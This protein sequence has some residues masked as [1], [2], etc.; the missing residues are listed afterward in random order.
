MDNGKDTDKEEDQAEADRAVGD[1]LGLGRV[2][3]DRASEPADDDGNAHQPPLPEEREHVGSRDVTEG[4]TGGTGPDTGG[5]GV[6]RRRSGA[7][8]TDIGR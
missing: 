5:S 1:V 8:G 6:F 2:T 4:T 7:T 3:P